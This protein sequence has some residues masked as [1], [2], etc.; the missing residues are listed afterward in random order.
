[1]IKLLLSDIFMNKLSKNGT[2]LADLTHNQRGE[3]EEAFS[4]S[5]FM[6]ADDCALKRLCTGTWTGLTN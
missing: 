6:W 4:S 1:M 5:I 3:P 2:D